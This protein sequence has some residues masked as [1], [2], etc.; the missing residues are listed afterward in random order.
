MTKVHESVHFLNLL[1][2]HKDYASFNNAISIIMKNFPEPTGLQTN[3]AL[4]DSKK[5]EISHW[6]R[7]VLN[8]KKDGTKIVKNSIFRTTLLI[9]FNNCGGKC[10][11]I[12]KISLL[13]SG[14][15]V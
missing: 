3:S 14:I 1:Y 4:E 13:K 11:Q 15:R 8:L 9:L 10:P 6:E 7:D 5:S 2:D 12:P